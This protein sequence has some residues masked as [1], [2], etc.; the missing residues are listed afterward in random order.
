MRL[1]HMN[2]YFFAAMEK[3]EVEVDKGLKHKTTDTDSGQLA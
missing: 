3:E 1:Q 2:V